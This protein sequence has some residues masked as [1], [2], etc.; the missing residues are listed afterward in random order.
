MDSDRMKFQKSP[1]LKPCGRMNC[2]IVGM[3]LIWSSVNFVY[4]VQI[5][6]WK[7]SPQALWVS[8]VE[9]RL[10]L[11]KLYKNYVNNLE[12]YIE[13]YILM[14]QLLKCKYEWHESSFWYK[15]Y[16]KACTN[17]N[18]RDLSLWGRSDVLYRLQWGKKK[19][20]SQ[21]IFVFFFVIVFDMKFPC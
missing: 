17:D 18:L 7:W 3:F 16:F 2:Y 1:S 20:Y 8:K 11:R 4:C 15:G 21:W 6:Y 12:N 10:Q 9:H 19:Q 5:K 14:N 13:K